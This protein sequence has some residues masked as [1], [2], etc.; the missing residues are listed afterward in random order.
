[1]EADEILFQYK[2][3][4]AIGDFQL[5]RSIASIFTKDELVGQFGYLGI[6]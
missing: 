6:I 5:C 1:M 3:Y 4:N 2:D